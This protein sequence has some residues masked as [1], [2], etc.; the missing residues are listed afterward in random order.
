MAATLASCVGEG[1]RE[2][3]GRAR[4]QS[5]AVAHQKRAPLKAITN[6]PV[7]LNS[8]NNAKARNCLS[9][10]TPTCTAP[11]DPDGIIS[12]LV[13]SLSIDD[14]DNYDDDSDGS[15]AGSIQHSSVRV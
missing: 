9:S 2:Q 5:T 4:S 7:A 11:A 14:D 3:R 8:I 13:C 6:L 1:P 12:D 15:V 10:P